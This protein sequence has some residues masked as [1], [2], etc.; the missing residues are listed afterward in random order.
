[1]ALPLTTKGLTATGKILGAHNSP[2]ATSVVQKR[3]TPPRPY[4]RAFAGIDL[5]DQ[6]FLA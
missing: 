1:M 2:I 3:V 6:T 4:G 5:V